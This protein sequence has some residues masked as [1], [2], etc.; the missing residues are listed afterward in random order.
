MVSKRIQVLDQTTGQPLVGANVF[1][2]ANNR[3]GSI[4]NIDGYTT[5][6]ALSNSQQFT[7]SYM[8]FNSRTYSILEMPYVIPLIEDINSLDTVI[9]TVPKPTPAASNINWWLIALGFIT[10]GAA[11]YLGSQ[12]NTSSTKKKIKTI[13]V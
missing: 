4:T 12:S 7:I 9:I 3:N 10:I 13:T 8:G 1:E 2:T 5:I 11:A 6:Q